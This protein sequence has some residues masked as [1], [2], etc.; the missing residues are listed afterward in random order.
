MNKNL[1]HEDF[2][3][4]DKRDDKKSVL[5][6]LIIATFNQKW[7]LDHVLKALTKQS[8][9]NFEILIADDGSTD[10]T[11]AI[12]LKYPVF[13]MTQENNGF[14]KTRVVNEASK[15]IKSN[16]IILLDGDCIP[17]KDFIKAHI[18]LREEGYYLGGRRIDLTEKLTRDFLAQKIPLGIEPFLLK[19]FW[20]VPKINRLLPIKN[21]IVRKLF[22]QDKIY[23]MMGCNGSFWYNDFLKVDGYDESY[24]KAHRE[25]GD[26]CARLKHSGLK[27]KSLKG[28]ALIYHL[29]HKRETYYQNEDMFKETLDKKSIK[30]RKGLSSRP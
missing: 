22:K 11:E 23:D 9:K 21:K 29:W 4:I 14:R 28:L 15:N 3:K 13:F 20:R 1:T 8:Y 7:C 26:L 27:I 25:D 16:Y 24:V 18:D 12:A 10:E 6:S 5:A 19:N 30:A 2:R 17:H